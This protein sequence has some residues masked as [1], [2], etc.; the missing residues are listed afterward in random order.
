MTVTSRERPARMVIRKRYGVWQ[1]VLLVRLAGS[2]QVWAR[3]H[4][5]TFAG[6]IDEVGP[7]LWAMFPP[8]RQG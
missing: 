1:A 7:A 8:P 6:M 2:D 3:G 4:S 5:I